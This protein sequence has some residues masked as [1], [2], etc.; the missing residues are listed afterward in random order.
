M[1]L[2]KY[3][4]CEFNNFQNLHEGKM[5]KNDEPGNIQ[6]ESWS[7]EPDNTHIESYFGYT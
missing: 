1:F 7:F 2:N 6:I 4:L 3:I 5:T